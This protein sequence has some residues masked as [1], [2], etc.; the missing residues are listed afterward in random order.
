MSAV[1]KLPCFSGVSGFV[2]TLVEDSD[3]YNALVK[4]DDILERA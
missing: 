4:A 1:A 2:K 3:K